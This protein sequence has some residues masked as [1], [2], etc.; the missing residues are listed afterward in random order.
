[1]GFIILTACLL[2]IGAAAGQGVNAV[3]KDFKLTQNDPGPD[4][5]FGYSVS[6]SGDMAVVG[7]RFD[8][9][10]F[11]NSGSAYVY[12]YNSSSGTWNQEQKL[13]ASDAA[14]DDFFGNENHS[15]KSSVGTGG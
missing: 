13:T 5:E 11:G 2:V 8:N 3:T 4:D 7:A 9:G 10:V 14:A 1:M 12:R 15:H 6:I